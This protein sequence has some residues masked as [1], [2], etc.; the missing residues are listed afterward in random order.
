MHFDPVSRG[1][2][3][4]AIAISATFVVG[5]VS[6]RDLPPITNV[7]V[8]SDVGDKIYL[9]HIGFMVFSNKRTPIDVPDWGMDAH[10]TGAIE[11]ALKERYTLRAVD[12]PRGKIAPELGGLALF[13][14]PSPDKNMR[15]NAKPANGETI[16]AYV[17]VWP[18]RR[19]VYP[20]NQQVE[21]IGLLTQGERARLYTSL[22][23]TLLE[24]HTFKEIDTCAVK[25]RP[26]SFGSP[27]GSYMNEANDLFAESYEAMTPEQK[28]KLEQ[29]LKAMVSD[30][31]AYCLRDLKLLN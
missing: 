10:I 17:V 7:G 20:T 9:Q 30:G 6:A 1:I 4:V 2:R 24:G 13:D 25:I 31:V 18:F 11:A 12:F 21:G 19:E 8:V 5:A 26:T 15:E 27:D 28:Q 22:M 3:A 29:G 23:V 14:G 16:D